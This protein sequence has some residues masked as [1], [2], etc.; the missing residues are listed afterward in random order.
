MNRYLRLYSALAATAVMAALASATPTFADDDDN[1]D[2]IQ[3]MPFGNFGG[4][5]MMARPVDT[6][7]DGIVSASEA[8]HHAGVGFALFDIDEDGQI[9]EDEYL[10]SAPTAMPRGRS[11]IER[12]YVNRI[13]RFK[14]MDVDGD[15]HVTLAEFMATAQENFEAADANSDGN[16]T[17][18]E[19][20]AQQRPF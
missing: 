4:M 7:A 16:V 15:T 17:V 1:D 20:R 11:N 19:F 5:N 18:W 3:F 13:A 2:Q 10:D 14:T 6:N 9:S 8:S 12:L